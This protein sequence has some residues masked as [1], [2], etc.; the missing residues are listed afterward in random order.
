MCKKLS[1]LLVLIGI[2]LT[3]SAVASVNLAAGVR[4]KKA[5]NK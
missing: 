1:F 4:T 3:L 5:G 2:F